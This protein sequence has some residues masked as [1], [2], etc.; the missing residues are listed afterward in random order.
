MDPNGEWG[1]LLDS[2]KLLVK[3]LQKSVVFE[4]GENLKFFEL[5]LSRLY[6]THFANY[7]AW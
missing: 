6:R 5:F 3:K 4:D 1:S 7:L 2:P